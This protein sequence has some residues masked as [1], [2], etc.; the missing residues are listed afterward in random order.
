L[1][2]SDYPHT[3]PPTKAP[4]LP[5]GAIIRDVIPITANR[6]HAKTED[7][8]P[9]T[10]AGLVPKSAEQ[11]LPSWA[12]AAT[13]TTTNSRI[14]AKKIPPVTSDSY[15]VPDR[16]VTQ[17][18][19]SFSALINQFITESSKEQ[20]VSHFPLIQLFDMK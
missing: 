7:Q 8:Q 3:L 11:Q 5:H 14:N 6:N 20:T 17:S 19:S 10:F 12:A 13:T 1:N 15:S 4:S 2:E 18:K 9:L 16:I